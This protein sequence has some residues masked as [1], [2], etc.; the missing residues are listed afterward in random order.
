MGANMKK[1]LIFLYVVLALSV[2]ATIDTNPA[3][4]QTKPL[5]SF[6]FG[7]YAGISGGFSV[8]YDGRFYDA[9]YAD[10]T[11][12]PNGGIRLGVDL[13]FY[14][15]REERDAE[16]IKVRNVKFVN[17][18]KGS[19]YILTKP[20]KYLYTDRFNNKMH[21][22]DY[23]LWLGEAQNAK[24][25][26]KINL[27]HQSGIYSAN[28][29]IT[30]EMLDSLAPLPVEVDIRKRTDGS[31]RVCF[32]KTAEATEYKVRVFNGANFIYDSR[33]LPSDYPDQICTRL[34]S[35][36]SGKSGR[37]EARLISG[38]WIALLPCS[39]GTGPNRFTY[40]KDSRASTLF[41]LEE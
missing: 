23:I 12:L 15:T 34:P 36:Y 13:G 18:T 31:Y 38:H 21:V 2:I 1:N 19:T 40:A 39:N 17:T 6:P 30:Q 24:G 16:A 22:A 3:M 11:S 14:R 37:V 5:C 35:V 28:F 20:G 25:V 7:S 32:Y 33:F 4:S 27:V 41:T 26:W 9:S 10:Q 8:Q 29:S